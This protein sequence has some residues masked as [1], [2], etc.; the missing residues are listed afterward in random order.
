[1]FNKAE[2]QEN[3]K[4]KRAELLILQVQDAY[5]VF[6]NAN[7]LLSSRKRPVKEM[8]EISMPLSF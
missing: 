8:T 4:K 2:P 3:V 7:E 6:P 1:M 5:R